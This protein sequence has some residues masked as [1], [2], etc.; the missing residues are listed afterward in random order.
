VRKICP[1]CKGY[2]FPTKEELETIKK[3]LNEDIKF[4]KGQGCKES[5]LQGI[6]VEK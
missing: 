2:Y 4:Y 3:F 5:V 6:W 1:Y